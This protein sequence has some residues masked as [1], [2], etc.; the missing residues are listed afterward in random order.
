[1]S[2]ASLREEATRLKIPLWYSPNYRKIQKSAAV[3]RAELIAHVYG[4][5][6]PGFA[7][8][9]AEIDGHI[10]LL[11]ACG[12]GEYGRVLQLGL[13]AYSSCSHASARLAGL[14]AK[15]RRDRDEEAFAAA[16]IAQWGAIFRAARMVYLAASAMRGELDLGVLS[17]PACAEPW[18]IPKPLPVTLDPAVLLNA[19]RNALVLARHAADIAPKREEVKA[20]GIYF[21]DDGPT[22]QQRLVAELGQ[23]LS[24]L[25]TLSETS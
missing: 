23:F 20:P 13:S 21:P 1:M 9:A 2:W 6:H 3:L 25:V 18:A 5:N 19:S 10:S 12:R 16:D 17:T 24:K 7:G 22:V 8:S 11:L 4:A 15:R 14:T